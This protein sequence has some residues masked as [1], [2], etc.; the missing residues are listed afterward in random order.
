LGAG[1]ELTDALPVG[2]GSFEI[3]LQAP[4]IAAL[5]Q[6]RYRIRRLRE[7][8]LCIREGWI[9]A[10]ECAVRRGAVDQRVNTAWVAPQDMI[11][12]G[13]DFVEISGRCRRFSPIDEQVGIV[14][15][16][17]HRLA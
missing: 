10:V 7:C 14:R 8:L 3:A 9:E 16:Q 5:E 2:A 6:P 12:V 17:A 15:P 1:G 11:K 4:N 13:N